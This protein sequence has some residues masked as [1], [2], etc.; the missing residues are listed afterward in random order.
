MI[1][2][3]SVYKIGKLGKAHGTN[4]ELNLNVELFDGEDLGEYL[5]LKMD[6][7]LV[8]FWLEEYRWRNDDTALVKLEGINTQERAREMA[9]VEV[10][11]PREM[12]GDDAEDGELTYAELVGFTVNGIGKIA[13]VDDQTENI[14][15]ELED[16]MLIPA[17][18]ELIEEIDTEK[19]TITMNLPEGLLEL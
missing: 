11:L 3:E 2:E 10:F 4:G 8:P 17:A 7:I 19:R 16:G 5:V 6:G 15:F 12:Q 1:K 9:N 14:M 18:E 13:F